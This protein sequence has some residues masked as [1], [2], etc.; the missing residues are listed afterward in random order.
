MSFVI[1]QSKKNIINFGFWQSWFSISQ[2]ISIFT[3][4]RIFTLLFSSPFY[5][6]TLKFNHSRSLWWKGSGK[7]SMGEGDQ[8]LRCWEKM[9]WST[10]FPVALCYLCRLWEGEHFTGD[11]RE[12]PLVILLF[13]QRWKNLPKCMGTEVR[14]MWDKSHCWSEA[15]TSNNS[16]VWKTPR[17]ISP[18]K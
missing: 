4:Q 11:R 2:N 15:C 14:S 16:G 5:Q 13:L 8:L 17:E 3:F 6:E 10:H 9:F 1:S 18:S 12:D 7:G